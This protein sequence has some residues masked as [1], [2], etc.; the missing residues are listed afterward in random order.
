MA[1]SRPALRS[2]GMDSAVAAVV[3]LAAR[4]GTERVVVG[5]PVNMDGSEGEQA[6]RARA[7]G[8]RLAAAGLSVEYRDERLTSWQARQDTGSGTRPADRRSG[9]VDSAAARLLLQEY[10]DARRPRRARSREP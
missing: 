5:L 6:S 3:E 9:L 4:E 8:E 10:L 7:F 2:R 1:F